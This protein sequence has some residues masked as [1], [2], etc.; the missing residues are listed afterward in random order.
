MIKLILALSLVM[1][2]YFIYKSRKAPSG[3]V[4]TQALKAPSSEILIQDQVSSV[5][6]ASQV[7]T[8]TKNVQS[9]GMSHYEFEEVFD[10]MEQDREDFLVRE[11]ELTPLIISEMKQL[12][13][14]TFNN[15]N[16]V[17]SSKHKTLSSF[18]RRRQVLDLEESLHKNLQKI[19]GKKRW[20]AYLEYREDYNSSIMKSGTHASGPVPFMDL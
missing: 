19:L 5:Q 17:F 14:T 4:L 1:N 2:G 7:K 18:D 10:K 3:V 12:K 13:E 9:Q 15:I 11:L 6:A 20:Q 16:L 8:E